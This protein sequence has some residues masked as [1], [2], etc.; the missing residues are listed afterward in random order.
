MVHF[1]AKKQKFFFSEPGYI[2]RSN[3]RT[4]SVTLLPEL[5]DI[6]LKIPEPCQ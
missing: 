1:A 5:G 2:A 4:K 6:I 3:S